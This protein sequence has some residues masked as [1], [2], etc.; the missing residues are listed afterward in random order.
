MVFFRKQDHLPD[1]SVINFLHFSLPLGNNLIT[2]EGDF[3]LHGL[4]NLIRLAVI[5]FED[6]D[7]TETIMVLQT[8]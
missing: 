3:H 1:F 2:C 4:K 5:S 7:R 8:A 6:L